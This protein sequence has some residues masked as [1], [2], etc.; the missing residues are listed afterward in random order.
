MEEK[1]ED[2]KEEN[3][4]EQDVQTK[5][6]FYKRAVFVTASVC[7]VVLLLFAFWFLSKPTEKITQ[8]VEIEDPDNV[9]SGAVLRLPRNVLNLRTPNTYVYLKLSLEFYEFELPED[10]SS[11][12]TPINDAII[13]IVSDKTSDQLISQEGREDLKKEIKQEIN[14][15]LGE[16]KRVSNI[17]YLEFMIKQE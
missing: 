17:Y 2:S 6:V 8:I 4:V 3:Q 11:S 16:N 12:I 13:R 9:L 10:I 15:I 1:P 5:V 7:L 14:N